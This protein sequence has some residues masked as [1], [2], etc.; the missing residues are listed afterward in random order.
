MALDLG[1]DPWTYHD[2][3]DDEVAK[4]REFEIGDA[5]E[6]LYEDP[7]FPANARSLY[8]DPLNPPRGSIPNE[9]LKWMRICEGDVAGCD[10]P[11]FHTGSGIKQGALGDR[12]FINALRLLSCRPQLLSR[13]L[14]SEK[15]SSQGLYT[16]KFN[17][18]GKWRYV[19]IDDRIACR[20]SGAVNFCRNRNPNET[21]G[22][23]LE[24]AYAKLHGNYE[25]ISFGLTERALMELSLGAVQSPRLG[26]FKKSR[27][28]DEV[29]ELLERGIEAHQVRGRDTDTQIPLF[30]IRSSNTTPSVCSSPVPIR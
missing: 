26:Q 30:T 5:L 6:G 11:V 24:K 3:P 17:K 16:L 10:Y 23:L 7:D 2:Y 28:C 15:Y 9:S 1:I 25:A 20:Q 4:Q 14:V 8:F 29:W 21:C 13:L 19:H 27:V 12:Y 18:A 22:M